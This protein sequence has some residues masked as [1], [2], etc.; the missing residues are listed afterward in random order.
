MEAGRIIHFEFYKKPMSSNMVL[1]ANT[2]LSETVKIASLKEEVVRRLKHTSLRLGLTKR[3]ETLEDL[4]QMMINSGHSHKFTKSILIGGIMRFEHKLKMSELDKSDTRYK[5][6]HQP[7][8]R[9]KQ[10]LKRKVMQKQNWYR[11]GPRN[12]MGINLESGIETYKEKA[13][14]GKVKRT[15]Q[16]D[17]NLQQM[18][19]STV[20]FVPNTKGGLLVNKLKG[21]EPVMCGLT[22]FM[23]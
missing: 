17:G 20:M 23:V 21:G 9:C 13:G 18:T 16:K 1:Q 2:A 7:S 12:D 11:D 8:G 22:G 4:S 6:L 5:P 15:I 10:R 19:T 3:L 14:K